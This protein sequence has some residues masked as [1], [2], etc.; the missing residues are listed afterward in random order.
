MDA[1]RAQVAPPCVPTGTFTWAHRSY[2][3]LGFEFNLLRLEHAGGVKCSEICGTRKGAKRDGGRL[4]RT[5]SY[6]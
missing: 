2:R 6:K 4:W 5:N 1:G 3:G